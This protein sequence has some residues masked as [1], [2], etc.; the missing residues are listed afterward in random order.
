MPPRS[1]S[2]AKPHT[3][4]AHPRDDEE[5]TSLFDFEETKEST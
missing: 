3:K 1:P 2:S 5:Q 4:I